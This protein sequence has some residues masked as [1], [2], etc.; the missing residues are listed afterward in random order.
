[1]KVSVV[2]ARVVE[3]GVMRAK[4][5]ATGLLA[6]SLL[7]AMAPPL[8]AADLYDERP[9]YGSAYED[10]R[11]RDIYGHRAPHPAYVERRDLPPPASVPVESYR[12]RRGYLAPMPPPAYVDRRHW[13]PGRE[14]RCL[15][16]HEIRRALQDDGWS[17]FHDLDVREADA[18]VHAYRPNGQLYRV[19][20][21]RCTG[22]ILSTRLIDRS[23]RGL[24][25]PDRYG[26][27]SAA[28]EPYEPEPS[29]AG[30]YDADRDNDAY[31]PP[32]STRW[33]GSTRPYDRR[34]YQ[35]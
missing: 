35:Y 7:V 12:D 33:D 2:K 13:L 1:M 8:R 23:D 26:S 11:Y 4:I 10:P 34:I 16:R 29:R 25:R 6:A 9:R 24:A 14:T 27:D 17:G 30:G 32:R 5:L 22:E 19:K 15:P 28:P 20:V 18:I 3:T 31:V 21:A